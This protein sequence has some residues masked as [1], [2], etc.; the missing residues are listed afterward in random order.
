MPAMRCPPAVL[1]EMALVLFALVACDEKAVPKTQPSAVPSATPAPIA[2]A[3]PS[4]TPDPPK[5]RKVFKCDATSPVVD[6]HGDKALEGEVRVKLQKPKGDVLKAEIRTI[7]SINLTK[8][9]NRMDEL[10]PCVFALFAS[11]KDLFLPGGDLDD[12]TPIQ[13]L[14][15]LESLRASDTKVKD[16]TPVSHLGKLDRLD[17]SR[18]PLIDLQPLKS[19]AV[20]TELQLD[21]TSITDLGPLR[22]LKKLQKLHLRN[23]PI[24]D[25]APIK[26]LRDLR[27]LELQGTQITDTSILAPLMGRGLKI[28]M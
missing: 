2:S 15:Q 8:N 18:T 14:V 27:L 24:Q 6:F 19:L 10:D 3:V 23:T 25:L 9:G 11:V 16:L 7:K 17:L 20:L 26:D 5:K 4:A 28:N 1:A 22:E 13:T 21:D 12:L